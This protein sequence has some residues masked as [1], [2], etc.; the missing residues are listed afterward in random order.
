MKKM[1]GCEYDPWNSFPVA[2]TK[3]LFAAVIDYVGYSKL[4]SLL[5]LISS[6][7]V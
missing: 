7:L 4:M 2:Y 1:R 5:L 6:T 3:K